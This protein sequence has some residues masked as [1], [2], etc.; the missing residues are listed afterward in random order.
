VTYPE[1]V[2]AAL[3]FGWIDGQKARDDDQHWLQRFTPRGQRSRWSKLNRQNATRLIDEGR[4][5]EAGLRAIEAARE[6]GRWAAAYDGSRTA[7]I[8]PDL[9]RELAADPA[10]R[11]AFDGLDAQDR[12]S[13][14]WRIND[15]KRPETRARRIAK[16]VALLR[17]GKPIHA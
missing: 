8:P 7:Q 11:R 4:M 9:D 15:A 13:V 16:Y 10:L 14:L 12:Y 5:R 6:D 17:A 2:E 1:A 3:C